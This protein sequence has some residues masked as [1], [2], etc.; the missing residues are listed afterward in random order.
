MVEG[1]LDF[2]LPNGKH[3][4]Y[5]KNIVFND[6]HVLVKGGNPASDTLAAPPELGVGQYNVSNLKIQPSYGIWARHVMG[7]TVKE[8]SFNYEQPDGRY[9]FFLDDVTGAKISSINTPPP[10]NNDPLIKLRHSSGVSIDNVAQH[11]A[12]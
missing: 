8:S 6:V 9:V 4:G 2:T 11:D 1:G 7:L 10:V 5:I 3:T 12:K